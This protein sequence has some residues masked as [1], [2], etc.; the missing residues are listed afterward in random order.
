ML[1]ARTK[2]VLT[3]IGSSKLLRDVVIFSRV[4]AGSTVSFLTSDA[5]LFE[6]CS[7]NSFDVLKQNITIELHNLKLQQVAK[8]M[9]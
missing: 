4:F 3:Y 2:F 5:A 8:I 7:V 1:S 6:S 9:Q